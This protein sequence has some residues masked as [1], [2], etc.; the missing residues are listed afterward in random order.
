M[1]PY[2]RSGRVVNLTFPY[3][4]SSINVRLTVQGE[5][6]QS[7]TVSMQVMVDY[8]TS[9]F[10]KEG[11]IST[12][13]NSFLSVPPFDGRTRG[14]VTLVTSERST[15]TTRHPSNHVAQG[16]LGE[17]EIEA[18]L[19]TPIDTAG[20]WRFDFNGAD[21]FVSGSIKVKS[22]QTISIDSRSVVFH[23]SGTPG[24]RIKF[25]FKLLP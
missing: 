6:G 19:A 11:N 25:T 21:G 8:L 9:P 12:A 16:R 15:P 2:T 24:E 20:V 10:L 7:D 18:Y 23:L 3:C 4:S 14:F 5:S 22:G 17:N 13:F 1:G